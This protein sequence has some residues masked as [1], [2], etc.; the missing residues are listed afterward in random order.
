[1]NNNELQLDVQN[2]FSSYEL[3]RKYNKSQTTIR[4]WLKKYGLKTQ[5]F[6]KYVDIDWHNVQMMIDSGMTWNDIRIKGFTTKSLQWA[7]FNN[8]IKMRTKSEAQR[9]AWKMGKITPDIYRTPEHR[10]IMSKFG[11]LKP[12]AG[13][14]KKIL[15]TK[16]D[17]TQ[18]W[19]QGSWEVRF[20]SFLDLKNVLWEKNKLGY[21]YEY[22]GKEH[23]YF[24]DFFLSQKELYVEVK[25]YE[26][27]RDRAKWSQF[28]KKLLIIKK[29][30]INDLEKWFSM[31]RW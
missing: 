16:K 4:Y 14:C 24:P 2:G 27:E 28:P 15:Y 31:L 29:E 6:S 9:L 10:K 7:V 21:K 13:R 30:E 20:A 23:S 3:A 18:V 1:M 8:K 22:N 12:R 11:G 26:T 17:G 5:P 19:L 25:G